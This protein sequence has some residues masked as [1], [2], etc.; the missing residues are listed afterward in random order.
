MNQAVSSSKSGSTGTHGRA[1]SLQDLGL[2]RHN[3]LLQTEGHTPSTGERLRRS[4][5]AGLAARDQELGLGPEA[6]LREPLR[7][8]LLASSTAATTSGALAFTTDAEGRVVGIEVVDAQNDDAQW[9]KLAE[10]LRQ[11]LAAVRL[12]VPAGAHGVRIVLHAEARPQLP[13]GADPGLAID[14][15]GIPL[16]RGAG[17][18]STRLSL[19]KYG[20]PGLSLAGDPVDLGATVQR[21]VHLRVVS[22][23]TVP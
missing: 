9:R 23:D 7:A 22:V 10:K 11:A 21:V 19:F 8:A 20:L 17:P 4:L 3:L 18:R 13:S 16:K 1:L 5:Q 12:K 6:P 15:F 2:G 14:A